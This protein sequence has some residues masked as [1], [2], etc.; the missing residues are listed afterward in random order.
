MKFCI[1]N[2]NKKI[3][4]QTNLEENEQQQQNIYGWVSSVP[5][6]K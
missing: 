1:K 3:T 4:M 5:E 2:I 6:R